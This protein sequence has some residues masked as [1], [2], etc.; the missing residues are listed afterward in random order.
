MGADCIHGA[1]QLP[2]ELQDLSQQGSFELKKSKSSEVEVLVSIPEEM[3]DVKREQE[4]CYK[5]EYTNVLW[6]EWNMVSDSFRLVFC[7]Y[8]ND[9]PLTKWILVSNIA[10]L[11]D[12]LGWCSPTITQMKI[13]LQH[14][15][16]TV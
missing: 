7:W 8:R 1:I 16:S 13:L 4:I 3:K 15:G 10:R 14:C 9:K 11:F 5:D 6:V 2:K 12:I